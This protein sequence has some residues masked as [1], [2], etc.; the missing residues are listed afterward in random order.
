MFF[1]FRLKSGRKSQS[2]QPRHKIVAGNFLEQQTPTGQLTSSSHRHG[3]RAALICSHW[4]RCDSVGRKSGEYDDGRCQILTQ[5]C[6]SF[7]TIN[8]N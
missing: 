4:A 3:D 5:T 2:F 7:E 8:L 1:F 6:S